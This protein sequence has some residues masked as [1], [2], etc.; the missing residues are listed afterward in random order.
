MTV[1]INSGNTDL[2][3]SIAKENNKEGW[4]ILVA[5]LNICEVVWKV[6]LSV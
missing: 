3:S 2:P 5:T 4:E 6:H 1:I